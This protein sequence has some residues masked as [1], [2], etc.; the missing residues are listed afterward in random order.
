M[1][2]NHSNLIYRALDKN[3]LCD[4]LLGSSNYRY[5][6]KGSPSPYGTD[7]AAL[8]GTLYDTCPLERRQETARKLE[9]SVRQIV[10]TYEGIIPTS[11]VILVEALAQRNGNSPFGLPIAS[12]AS[13]LKQSIAN[14]RGQLAQDKTGGGRNWPDGLLGELRRLSVNV[15]ELGGPPF[16][17]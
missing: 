8:L 9:T 5:L 14:F 1:A 15:S 13:E 12:L 4:L 2:T 6:P 10:K 11:I 3:Q 7:L 17:E 16:F